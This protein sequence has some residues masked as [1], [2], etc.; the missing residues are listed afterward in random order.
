MII[1]IVAVVLVTLAT[2][3]IAIAKTSSLDKITGDGYFFVGEWG[4]TEIW[5]TIEIK[6]DPLTQQPKGQITVK[7]TNPYVDGVRYYE[8]TPVCVNFFTRE[9]GTP[10]AIVVSRITEDGVSGFGPGEPLEYAKW[11]IHDSQIPLGQT[12]PELIDYD[13]LYLAYECMGACDTNGDGVVDADY[14]EFWPA[15]GEPPACD[16]SD[17]KASPLEVDEGNFM[18]H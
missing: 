5:N 17:F 12:D 18:I 13:T 10:W 11:M 2:V 9:D 3:S 8:T 16:E 15:D 14:D 1:I 4:D 6:V 7:I